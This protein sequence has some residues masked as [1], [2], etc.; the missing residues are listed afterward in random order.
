MRFW[1]WIIYVVILHRVYVCARVFTFSAIMSRAMHAISI[2]YRI[3]LT[4]SLVWRNSYRLHDV[5]WFSNLSD[6]RGRRTF[7]VRKLFRTFTNVP[8][9]DSAILSIFRYLLA[10][11]F[12]LGKISLRDLL[13]LDS[14]QESL[15]LDNWEISANFK[16]SRYCFRVLYLGDSCCNYLHPLQ[17][18]QTLIAFKGSY[19]LCPRNFQS[20]VCVCMCV[21]TCVC[22]R[23]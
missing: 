4:R 22:A 13:C 9:L 7:R 16:T 12:Q 19:K 6:V 18:W 23:A 8:V 10:V 17:S 3:D 20:C 15:I 1:R 14:R 11:N 5:P 2:Y 21:F